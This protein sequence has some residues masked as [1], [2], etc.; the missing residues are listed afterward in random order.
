MVKKWKIVLLLAFLIAVAAIV[1]GYY[2]IVPR[3][4]SWTPFIRKGPKSS[5]IT[6]PS[7]TGNIDSTVKALLEETRDIEESIIAEADESEL[8][9]QDSREISDFGQSYNEGEF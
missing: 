6:P 9:N 8:I 4:K 5:G 2:N 1:A 3:E 7:A